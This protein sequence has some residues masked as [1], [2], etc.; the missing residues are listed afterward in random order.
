MATPWV[1]EPLQYVYLLVSMV[2]CYAFFHVLVRIPAINWLFTV[3]TPTHVY[4]RYHEPETTLADLPPRQDASRKRDA[5]KMP[6]S[7]KR[8]GG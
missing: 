1:V 4:R 5:G 8:L 7:R 6:R 2:I 3:T